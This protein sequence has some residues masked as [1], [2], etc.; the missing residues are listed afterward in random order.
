MY[1]KN[2]NDVLKIVLI[3]SLVSLNT[4]IWYEILGFKFAIFVILIGLAFV[5]SDKK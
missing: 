2:M 4:V 3:S 1:K 5:L